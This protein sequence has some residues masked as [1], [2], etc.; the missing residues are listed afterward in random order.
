MRA[1]VEGV[2]E[3]RGGCQGRWVGLMRGGVGGIRSGDR[4][5]GLLP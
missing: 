2:A 3:G 1:G 5:L 4:D